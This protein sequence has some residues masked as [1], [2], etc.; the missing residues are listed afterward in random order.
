M[1]P[2]VPVLRQVLCDKRNHIY[3]CKLLLLIA[4][5]GIP[6]DEQERPDIR[7]LEHVLGKERQ[8]IHQIPM[9]FVVCTGERVQ[10]LTNVSVMRS[11]HRR[12]F[13]VY[14]ISES[15]G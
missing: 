7:T 3:E 4:T 1:T 6:T 5:D 15:V 12:W 13:T 2:L 14:G 8:L 9:T 11:N 10:S